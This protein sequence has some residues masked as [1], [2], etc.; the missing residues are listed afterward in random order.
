VPGTK[1]IKTI[2]DLARVLHPEISWDEP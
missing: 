2:E 1:I